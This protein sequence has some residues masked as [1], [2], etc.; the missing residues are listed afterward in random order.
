MRAIIFHE[1]SQ[2]SVN[3]TKKYFSLFTPKQAPDE[4]RGTKIIIDDELH[5][6]QTIQL[7]EVFQLSFLFIELVRNEDFRVKKCFGD[8]FTQKFFAMF[9]S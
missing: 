3:D 9:V 6:E 4:W 7:N 2:F 1:T 8:D 5:E